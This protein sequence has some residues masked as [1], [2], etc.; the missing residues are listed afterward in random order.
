MTYGF[1]PVMG[2]YLT[3]NDARLLV[4]LD[5]FSDPSLK[6]LLESVDPSGNGYLL[7]ARTHGVGLGKEVTKG[8]MRKLWERYGVPLGND[9]LGMLDLNL[10]TL[11]GNRIVRP[12]QSSFW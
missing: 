3:L 6:A 12:D 1:G 2:Y 11:S 7:T 4:N 10:Q 5:D 9:G 8:A